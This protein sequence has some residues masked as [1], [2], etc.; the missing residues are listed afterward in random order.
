M[1]VLEAWVV[2]GRDRRFA[3]AWR[4]MHRSI[5][6]KAGWSA[7][8]ERPM[9]SPRRDR[10]RQR[11]IPRARTRVARRAR[12]TPEADGDCRRQ[13]P[14]SCSRNPPR[15]H[16][17]REDCSDRRRPLKAVHRIRADSGANGGRE[18]EHRHYLNDLS[19]MRPRPRAGLT[20]SPLPSAARSRHEFARRSRVPYPCTKR[21][22]SRKRSICRERD[23]R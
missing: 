14:R 21:G 12:R 7:P 18:G 9:G 3:A 19:L 20:W 1:R 6:S 5:D 22:Q 11:S 10:I 17:K 2:E 8:S 16:W 13:D 15:R 23:H 4:R